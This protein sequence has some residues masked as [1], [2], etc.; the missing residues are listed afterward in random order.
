MKYT[1]EGV[2]FW[3]GRACVQTK[4]RHYCIRYWP[5]WVT[6][7]RMDGMG[8]GTWGW[9]KKDRGSGLDPSPK[10]EKKDD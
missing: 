5:P 3:K 1:G 10:Q 6:W 8:I 7:Y 9:L 2:T 4:K